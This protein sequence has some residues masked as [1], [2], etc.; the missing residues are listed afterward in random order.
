LAIELHLFQAIM[1]YVSSYLLDLSLEENEGRRRG[2]GE[3]GGGRRRG[4]GRGRREE[5]GRLRAG[6]QEGLREGL[7]GIQA[8]IEE[9]FCFYHI[10]L[11]MPHKNHPFQWVKQNK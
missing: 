3:E 4:E 7:G 11:P 6:L 1:S 5:G 8:E 9:A 2:G 10:H